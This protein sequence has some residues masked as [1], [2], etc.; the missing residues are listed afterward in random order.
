MFMRRKLTP[1][2]LVCAICHCWAQEDRLLPPLVA[3]HPDERETPDIAFQK[4]V[5]EAVMI[6]VRRE[7]NK[8]SLVAENTALYP[9]TLKFHFHK[10]RNLVPEPDSTVVF[11]VTPGTKVLMNLKIFDPSQSFDFNFKVDKKIGDGN[12]KPMLEFPYLM[13]IAKNRSVSFASGNLNVT[14]RVE[15]V[16]LLKAGDTVHAMRKGVV[17]AVPMT[18]KEIDRITFNSI[19]IRHLDGTIMAY[20][21]MDPAGVLVKLGETVFPGQPLGFCASPELFVSLYRQDDEK[22]EKVEMLFHVG[23]NTSIPFSQIENGTRVEHPRMLIEKEMNKIG[24]A[25][26]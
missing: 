7:I 14:Q 26:V 4:R 21:D 15:P 18:N 1:I 25:H 24:R 12:A 8:V 5:G 13:P 3:M 20:E 11:V 19:E 17:T 10:I 9:Y 23:Q 6:D 2:F 22:L 16:F